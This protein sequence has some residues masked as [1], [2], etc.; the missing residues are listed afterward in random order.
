MIPRYLSEMWAA[1]APALGNHLWQS[2]LFAATAGLL[3][4]ILRKDRAR[5]RYWLWLA[6]SLKFLI[7]FSLL[8][9]IGGHLAW[10]SRSAVTSTGLYF[11]MTEVSQPFTQL[12]LPVRAEALPT[13]VPQSLSHLFPIFIAATWLCGF[14]VVAKWKLCAGWSAMEEYEG[15]SRWYCRPPLSNPVSS[16]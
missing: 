12:I 16:V 5:A 3:T 6:A 2:T 11:A 13:T 14:V 10:S 7:P 8:V 4:L 9:I 1:L 15:A